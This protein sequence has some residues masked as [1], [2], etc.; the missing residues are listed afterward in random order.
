MQFRLWAFALLFASALP[1]QPERKPQMVWQGEVD[2]TALLYVRGKRLEVETKG[3]SPVAK[4][5]YRI[6]D[7][8]PD[9]RQDAHLK[10]SE[11]RGNVRIAEQPRA[12]NRFT[13]AL[14]IEDKQAG[15][16]FY[17]IALY[18]DT[19]D[20]YDRKPG[21]ADRITWSGRVDQEVTVSCHGSQCDSVAV[22]GAPVMH[23]R[24]KISR[25]LPDRDVKVSLETGEGRGEVRLL[26]QPAELNGY[27]A[28][29]RIRDPQSGAGDYSFALTWARQGRQEPQS[30]APVPGVVWSGRVE[31]TVRVTVQGGA[32][33]SKVINGRPVAEEHA[34][35]DRPLPAR[36][37]LNPTV[38]KRQGH[39]SV[40]VIEL[41]SGRNGYQL[42]FEVRDD[43]G[44]D[45]YEVEVAW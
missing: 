6:Y 25:P 15:S 33:F 22:S 19:G 4:Q 37:D 43:G 38:K 34:R 18:W 14:S 39:G 1:A 41:P 10:V 17:S 28:R 36:T 27:T 12:D 26:E 5:R 30:F 32:A 7:P 9:T 2:E 8:L 44:T 23:E 45:F 20:A 35:F 13:L 31:G 40:E 42:V 11:G 21:G 3:G 24:V 29:V 16:G